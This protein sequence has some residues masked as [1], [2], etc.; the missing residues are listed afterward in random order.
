[1][2]TTEPNAAARLIKR[3][4]NRKM[5]DTERSCYVTLEEVAELVRGG[6]DVHVVDNTTKEDLTEVTLTQALLDS[7]RKNRQPVSLA[8][9]RD[10][11]TH[12]GDQFQRNLADSVTRARTDVERTVEKW[13]TE[14]ERKV[15]RVLQRREEGADEGHD[16]VAL[17]RESGPSTRAPAVDAAGEQPG[18]A[19]RAKASEP[20]HAHVDDGLML[21]LRR[22][23]ELE[24]RIAALERR[25]EADSKKTTKPRLQPTGRDDS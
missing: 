22:F 16:G 17:Q 11:I 3:Y 5:Y 20:A 15:G 9:L 4:A 13:R 19:D 14:A 1:M 18:G 10:L 8:G 6:I 25:Q 12:S 23:D 7:R 24:R 2:P 21:V